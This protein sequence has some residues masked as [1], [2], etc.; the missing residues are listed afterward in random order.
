MTEIKEALSEK[1]AEVE[2]WEETT[3]RKVLDKT[4]ERKKNF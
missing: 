3:L 4:P 2:R 1:A